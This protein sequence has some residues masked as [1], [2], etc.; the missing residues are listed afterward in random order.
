MA[1]RN[2]PCQSTSY[3]PH[4]LLFGREM[5]LPFDI[6]LLPKPSLGKDAESHLRHLLEN[7]KVAKAIARENMETS[8]EINKAYQ[9]PKSQEPNF[10]LG[11]QVFLHNPAV[12]KGLSPKLTQP[13]KGPYYISA[14][15][16]NHT[17]KL[18]RC[19]DN[20][21]HKSMV[22]ANRLK[23]VILRL[24]DGP[25][26]PL[27]DALSRADLSNASNQSGTNLNEPSTTEPGRALPTSDDTALDPS[28]SDISRYATGATLC[29]ASALH[30]SSFFNEAHPA[31][32]LWS[33]FSAP[34]SSALFHGKLV[35]YLPD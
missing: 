33:C 15:G 21:E 10:S 13:W 34:S 16:P 14:T 1:M 20:M 5:H 30:H 12:T 8:Q 7:L 31:T 17:F 28:G 2:T 11:Q 26:Q 3:S 35:T 27:S 32:E 9:H 24:N 19:S 25:Q 4:Y 29:R 22:H 18:H 23:P 6:S